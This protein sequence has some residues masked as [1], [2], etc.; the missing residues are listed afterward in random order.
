QEV[1]KDT[2]DFNFIEIQADPNEKE[3][4]DK[5]LSVCYRLFPLIEV[6]HKRHNSPWRQNHKPSN[7][8]T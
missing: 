7:T 3:L 5:I 8:N 4:E 2:Y 6:H 1:F